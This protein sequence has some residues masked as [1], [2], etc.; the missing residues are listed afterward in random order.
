MVLLDVYICPTAGFITFAF[1]SWWD[2]VGLHPPLYFF[3]SSVFVCPVSANGSLRANSSLAFVG[4]VALSFSSWPS[5][6]CTFSFYGYLETLAWYHIIHLPDR[7]LPAFSLASSSCSALI[8]GRTWRSRGLPSHF[9]CIH[10]QYRSLIAVMVASFLFDAGLN[11]Y[12]SFAK[13]AQASSVKYQLHSSLSL[14]KFSSSLP[15]FLLNG[16]SLKKM[17]YSVKFACYSLSLHD[18]F[19]LALHCT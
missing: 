12:F 13:V 18:C 4:L 2:L 9:S 17:G 1:A 5:W 16:W 15:H 8:G 14:L 7:H 19:L 11:S 6:Q 10:G 3:S